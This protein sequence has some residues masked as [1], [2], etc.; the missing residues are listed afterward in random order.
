[1]THVR[2]MR[3]VTE[4]LPTH[5]ELFGLRVLACGID[6]ATEL[7]KSRIFLRTPT[8][9]AFMNANLS[10]LAIERTELREALSDFVLFNDGVGIEIANRLLNRAC[11]EANLNGTDFIPNLFSRIRDPLRIFLLGTTRPTLDKVTSIINERWPHHRVV[12]KTPGYFRSQQTSIAKAI[13]DAR[14]DVVLVAM[15]NPT[16]E[17]WIAQNIPSCA[18]CAIGVGG[19]FDFMAGN[20]RRA[21]IWVR[22]LRL[23]WLFRL[24]QEP[25]RLWRRYLIGNAKFIIYLFLMALARRRLS[26]G[27]DSD[28]VQEIGGP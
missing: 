27:T 19:L 28:R 6:Q 18:P 3:S 13:A 10:L 15:G 2:Y 9:I 1:M 16:Q 14:A 20:V 8:R 23:E 22:K 26:H 17:L 25:R 12:G 5:Y 4:I 24:Y 11:F 7:I 21:P